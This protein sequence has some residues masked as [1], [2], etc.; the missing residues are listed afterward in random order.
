MTRMQTVFSMKSTRL[1]HSRISISTE[2][3]VSS[4][5]AH[6]HAC[7]K[8]ISSVPTVE[9]LRIPGKRCI[10]PPP[11]LQPSAHREYPSFA[12]RRKAAGDPNQSSE[13][14][15]IRTKLISFASKTKRAAAGGQHGAQRRPRPPGSAH[16]RGLC[17][18]ISSGS[19]P[20]L[21]SCTRTG[22][23]PCTGTSWRRAVPPLA[24]AAAASAPAGAAHKAPA[25]PAPPAAPLWRHGR[26]PPRPHT[27]GDV[28]RRGAPA[29]P[30][31]HGAVPPALWRHREA[32]RWPGQGEVGGQGRGA[33]SFS[34]GA[35]I[36]CPAACKQTNKCL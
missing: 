2:T 27:G 1:T 15:T 36:Y 16:S 33:P 18:G 3:R 20:L 8:K 13:I 10:P 29:A 12:L 4:F 5:P 32:P 11:T 19:S 24:A 22:D 7:Q 26:A 31:R 25:A 28:T 35:L 17:R 23:L 34:V 30:W 6:P 21:F 14:T 9:S